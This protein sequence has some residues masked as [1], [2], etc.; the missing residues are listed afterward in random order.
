MPILVIIYLAILTFA[1]PFFS[2]LVHSIV[3][4]FA[5]GR[6]ELKSLLFLLYLLTLFSLKYLPGLSYIK[7]FAYEKRIFISSIFVALILNFSSFLFF[8]SKNSFKINDWILT[9]NNDEVS[10]TSL[11]HN[12]ILKGVVGSFLALFHITSSENLDA[13]FVYQNIFPAPVFF[14]IGIFICAILVLSFKVFYTQI[15]SKTKS[16]FIVFTVCYAVLTFS[17]IKNIIDGGLF[18]YEAIVS[19]AFLILLLNLNTRWAKFVTFSIIFFYAILNFAFYQ[20]GFFENF[21]SQS[22]SLFFNLFQTITYCLGLLPFIY[23]LDKKTLDRKGILLSTLGIIFIVVAV[24]SDMS[25]INYRQKMISRENY[26]VLAIYNKTSDPDYKH[27]G[28]IGR[29]NIYNLAPEKSLSVDSVLRKFNLKDNFYPLSFPFQSCLPRGKNEEYALDLVTDIPV[30]PSKLRSDFV[31]I[32]N[33]TLEKQVNGLYF[34][35]VT[36][37]IKQ[38]TPRHVNA[39]QEYFGMLGLN[40]YYILNIRPI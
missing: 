34:Y 9:L 19:L 30:D 40:N 20:F 38:C 15:R 28:S 25:I 13:G 4:V 39:I 6:S 1:I 27:I 35:N 17:L 10:S 32:N 8:I 16:E 18:N 37:S 29:L 14:V 36:I 7:S 31:F 33:A 24:A 23:F 22:T 11:V 12:H 26:A 5:G 3:N 21:S 2:I